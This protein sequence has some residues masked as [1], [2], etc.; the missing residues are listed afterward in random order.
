MILDSKDKSNSDI[1]LS[2]A[3]QSMILDMKVSSK[4]FESQSQSPVK[5]ADT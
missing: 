4:G 1:T 3:V 5:Q 2:Y